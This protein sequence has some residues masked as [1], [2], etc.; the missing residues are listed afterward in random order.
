MSKDD[1]EEMVEIHSSLGLSKLRAD[2]QRSKGLSKSPF[3]S[4]IIL[5]AA[6]DFP[7]VLKGSTLLIKSADVVIIPRMPVTVLT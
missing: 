5:E 7:P 1:Q 4:R 3:Q 6:E 2:L